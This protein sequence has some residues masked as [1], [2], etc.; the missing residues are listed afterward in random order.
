MSDEQLV[1]KFQK[2]QNEAFDELVR[3]YQ[4]VVLSTAYRLLNDRQDAEDAA[5]D[6]FVKV[7]Q[8]LDNFQPD[9]KFSTWL[10]RITVNHCLN[11]LRARKRRRWLSVFSSYQKES[12]S[13]LSHI[14]D[15]S[16][17]P[18]NQLEQSERERIVKLAINSLPASQR[19]ALIL[20]RYQGLSYKEVAEVM[21]TSVSSVESRIHRAK[22]Q[23]G[24]YLKK[25][26]NEL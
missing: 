14:P 2:G 6:I 22:K 12:P 4:Q 19:T 26:V 7:Y 24:H 15:E 10:Y 17:N 5:Q 9:A 16:H 1:E 21:G 11:V 18:E 23:L 8:A 20:H 13:Q 3:Q 25:Y